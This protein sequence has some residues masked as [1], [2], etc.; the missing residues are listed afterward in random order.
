MQ[1]TRETDYAIRC[2]YYLAGKLDEVIMVDEISKEMHV[3]KSFLAKILQKLSRASLVK[4]YRGVKG[5]FAL[6]RHP[7]EISLFDV[8]K[9]IQGPILINI[10]AVDQKACRLSDTCVI[11]PVW[12]DIRSQVEMMLKK[13]HFADLLTS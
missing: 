8:I 13:K 5:G 2:V 10:C 12:I 6:A 11:H 3:P 7:S 1:I 4:S 9:A